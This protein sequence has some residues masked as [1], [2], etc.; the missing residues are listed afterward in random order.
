LNSII[1]NKIKQVA[2]IA[3]ITS[4]LFTVSTHADEV[5]SP[6]VVTAGRLAED[7][8]SVSSDVTVINH[9][10]IERSQALSAA[11][12]LRGQTGVHVAASGGPGK[13]TS[14]YLRG[15]NPGQ[16][17]VLIDGVRV[18]SS[19]T[20]SFD[21]AHL[22]TMDI[23]RI[24]IVRGPQ[25][26]LYGAD[27]MG[28]VIQ[29]FTKGGA[30]EFQ[31]SA[32]VE[33]GGYG[34]KS[35]AVYVGGGG[36]SGVRYA[37][38]GEIRQ[39][40][41]ISAAANGVEP[42]AYRHYT[43]SGKFNI[44]IG[45]GELQLLGRFTQGKND[46]DGGTPFGDVLTFTNTTRQD[47]LSLK[48]SYPLSDIGESSLQLSRFGEKFVSRDPA[49]AVNDADIKTQTRELTWQNDLRWD[50]LS[51]LFGL[52][53]RQ[54][55]GQNPGQ[56]IDRKISQRAGFA[57]LGIHAE[58]YDLS[59]GARFDQNDIFSNQT[60]YRL[61]AVVR[62]WQGLK[63]TSNYGTGFKAPSINDLYWPATA[64]SSGNSNLKP[65]KSRGWDAGLWLDA[66]WSGVKAELGAVW[67]WQSFKNLIA[68]A[69]TSPGFWQPSN[70]GSAKT[71]GLELS[72]S[73][74]WGPAYL[75][76]NWTFLS[77]RNKDDDTWLNRRSKD[78]GSVTLGAEI[79]G[80]S[81]EVQTDIVGPRFSGTGNTNLMEGY[82]K[83]DLRFA[84]AVNKHWKLKA[85]LEN[86]EDKKYEEVSGYG[87][88]GRTF[89]GGVSAVF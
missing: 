8:S 52:N 46:L 36:N 57:T 59:A 83:T 15:A 81:A 10:Q 33:Y 49:S 27:A 21:W 89:Y 42:D 3:A 70:V 54:D 51:A 74:A 32:D 78:S 22:S 77:A 1:S 87:V 61:G 41:G 9:Q 75:R 35:S 34:Y 65:E 20:G 39:T 69:E 37:I 53:L 6:L 13:T 60:T 86:V 68:W 12:V 24:E 85:R 80:F 79:K 11:D 18:G 5:L 14:V 72:G 47:V 45:L 76:A 17:L 23:E 67:F 2:I 55:R 4:Q 44:P 88:L 82:H 40:D 26:T 48:A 43:A 71:K 58:H 28:G 25:S 62:P 31:A 50:V 56:N 63:L 7:I 38:N 66:D 19:T 30:G 84:Y 73:L 64:W 29:I 16:A